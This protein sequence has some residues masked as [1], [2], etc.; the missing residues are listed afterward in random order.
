MNLVIVAHAFAPSIGGVETVSRI[1]CEQ[2]TL[3]GHRV[4]VLTMT[5]D[6]AG[7]FD[8]PYTVLRRPDRS[9]LYR[10]FR[11]A[12]AVIESHITLGLTWPLYLGRLLGRLHLPGPFQSKALISVMHTPMLREND[13]TRASRLKLFLLKQIRPY[14]V[15]EYLRQTQG[16]PCGLIQNPYDDKVFKRLPVDDVSD[17]LLFVGRLTA[18]KGC[19]VAID[20]V[21]ALNTGELADVGRAPFHL[22]IVGRGEDEEELRRQALAHG[23]QEFIHFRGPQTPAV[24]ARTMNQHRILLMPS[25]SRPP[26]AFGLVAI[27]AIACGCIPIGSQQGGLAEAIDGCGL[28]F[29]EGDVLALARSVLEARNLLADRESLEALE[30]RRSTYLQRF[31]PVNVVAEY[32]RAV[33][34]GSGL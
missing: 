29:P 24:L 19:S 1:L 25:A 18:A 12:D 20:A 11:Q 33:T 14:A 2:L 7:V 3:L 31:L 6:D 28:T 23:Q 10:V 5:Q 16:V 4:T 30:Q 34:N 21:A 13:T 32:L 22:D 26:E 17:N 27:E 8:V 9:T 15:S